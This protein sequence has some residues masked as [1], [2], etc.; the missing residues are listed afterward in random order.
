M[1]HIA[2]VLFAALLAPL[3]AQAPAGFSYWSAAELKKYSETLPAKMNAQKLAAAD[4][5]KYGNHWTSITY[6][7]GDGEAEVHQTA[8]DFFVVEGGEAT[9][10]VGGK[11]MGQRETGK[12]EFRGK[13]IQGGERRKLGVGDIVHIP[14]NTPHQLFVPKSF[15]YFVIKV[16]TK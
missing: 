15:T 12:G 1:K 4:L 11:V 7:A 10:V 8:A 5:A 14:Q 9:L 3:A 2:L 6:R 16:E 13:S